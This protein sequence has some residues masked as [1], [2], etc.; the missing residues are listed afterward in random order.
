[1]Q[2]YTG[3]DATFCT[4]GTGVIAMVAVIALIAVIVVEVTHSV[5]T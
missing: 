4:L 5:P 2:S 1:M 3:A